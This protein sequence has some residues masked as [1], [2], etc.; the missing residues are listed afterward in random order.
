M[1][2]YSLGQHLREAREA[3]E[4]EIEDAVAKLRIRQP[5]L[6]SFEA[7][8]FEIEGLPQIQV[9]GLLRIYGRYLDLDEEQV[10]QLYDQ[11]RIA[12][13]KGR[14]ARRGRRR[15]RHEDAS[16]VPA[17]GTQPLQELEL[18]ERR[19][20]GCRRVARFFLLLLCTVAAVALIAYVSVEL[21]GLSLLEAPADLEEAPSPAPTIAPSPASGTTPTGATAADRAQYSGSGVLL[22]VRTTQR[23]W[24][25]LE[26]DGVEQYSGIAPPETALEI[27]ALSEIRLTASNAMALELRWNEQPQ[28]PI[29]ARGQQ[30]DLRFTQDQVFVALGELGAATPLSPTAT[31]EPPPPATA[32]PSASATPATFASDATLPPASPTPLPSARPPTSAPRPSPTPTSSDTPAPTAI[33]PPRLTQAGLPPTKAGA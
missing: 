21:A 5:I 16:R 24:L 23:T 33:L 13:E 28:G 11:M 31:L 26:A 27:A 18:A 15:R 22:H 30:A 1:D 4:I 2:A 25:R 9:R 14:R 17:S 20:S 29:G 6:E 8:E 10:L 19:A 32:R 12:Q 7:G 3:N